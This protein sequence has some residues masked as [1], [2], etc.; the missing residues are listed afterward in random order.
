[1]GHSI[2]S[3]LIENLHR[4]WFKSTGSRSI[5]LSF[6]SSDYIHI[7]ALSFDCISFLYII[8]HKYLHLLLLV[9]F[10]LASFC[11]SHVMSWLSVS[12]PLLVVECVRT[13]KSSNEA[14]MPMFYAA[15]LQNGLLHVGL[16]FDLWCVVG[17]NSRRGCGDPADEP[18]VSILLNLRHIDNRSAMS[19]RPSN[20]EPLE[21]WVTGS[22]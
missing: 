6:T 8:K 20:V 15:T 10:L 17:T 16:C 18:S 3:I 9:L 14:L 5:N 4:R 12:T 19:F 2:L 13:D 11:L 22:F 21:M 1:M 7:F